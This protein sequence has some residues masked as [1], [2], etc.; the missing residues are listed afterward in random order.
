MRLKEESRCGRNDVVAEDFDVQNHPTSTV[1]VETTLPPI[2]TET[3]ISNV[4]D[5]LRHV[6]RF[7][8]LLIRGCL[9]TE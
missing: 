1:C 6:P 8:T 3:E 9:A 5:V 4:H 7:H 2:S